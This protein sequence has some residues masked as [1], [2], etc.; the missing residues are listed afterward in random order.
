MMYMFSGPAIENN[1]EQIPFNSVQWIAGSQ[2]HGT[3]WP[4]RLRMA[5]DL[6]NSK[7]LLGKS[8]DEVVALLGFPDISHTNGSQKTI[9]YVL[10]PERSLFGIDSES[11]VVTLDANRRVKI[12][13]NMR[14]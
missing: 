7:R 10:G 2:D 11:I 4:T 12:V 3:L 9:E 6:V 5:D 13:E 8:K 1:R 14:R